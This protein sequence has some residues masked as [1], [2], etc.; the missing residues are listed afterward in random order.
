MPG[1]DLRL[2]AAELRLAR[3]EV[4]K[5]KIAAR[6]GERVGESLKRE[7]RGVGRGDA[8][9]EGTGKRWQQADSRA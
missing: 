9:G 3:V 7:G 1:A 5:G 8:R 2:G 6:V 4:E